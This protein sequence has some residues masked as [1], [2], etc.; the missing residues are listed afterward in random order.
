VEG[1]SLMV[2]EEVVLQ[3]QPGI[4]SRMVALSDD[5]LLVRGYGAP[6]PQLDDTVHPVPSRNANRRGV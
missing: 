6:D 2:A 1:A 3:S 4:L 5:V